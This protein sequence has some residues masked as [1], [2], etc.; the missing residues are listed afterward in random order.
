MTEPETIALREPAQ[1]A[2]I[3][4][5]IVGTAGNDFWTVIL[6][7]F[8][9]IDGLGGKDTLDF[10]TA[11]RSDFALTH[12]SEGAI[13]IDTVSGAS[14]AFHTTA[15]NVEIL[16]FNNGKDK[17]DVATFFG[18]ITPPTLVSIDP[19]DGAT[20][21]ASGKNIKLTFS[22]AVH[23]SAG[24]SIVLKSGLGTVVET[25][26][27]GSSNISIAGNVLTIDPTANLLGHTTYSLEVAAGTVEDLSGNRLQADSVATFSTA[28]GVNH[29]PSGA[30]TI[31]GTPLQGQVMS[32]SNTLVDA[33]G[34]GTLNYQWTADG[35]AIVGA[36]SSSYTLSQSVINSTVGVT[37]SYIDG[38]GNVEHVSSAPSAIIGGIY[39]GGNGD[40]FLF[41]GGG[42]DFL[43]GGGGNDILNGLGGSDSYDGGSGVD[44]A[45]FAGARASFTFT[46]ASVDRGGEHV[47]S[48]VNI[49]RLR[50]DDAD[51][52]LDISGNGG[53]A[54]RIY[55]AAFN[56]APDLTGLGF[57]ISVMDHGTTLESVAGGFVASAEWAKLYGANPSNADVVNG[58]YQNVL[59]RAPDPGG[60]KFWIDVLD[61]HLAT[62]PAVLAA[63]SESPEN[64]AALIGAI[65]NGFAYTPFFG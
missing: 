10:G 32:A 53:Q 60:V 14:A 36:T 2:A 42:A 5:N 61:G 27:I 9:V 41:G 38:Q 62:L 6:P 59:H 48:I 12:D 17:L 20:A 4:N 40:D 58:L 44:V 47:G 39:N 64:Q 45:V 24:G 29:A 46:T 26:T 55:Q 3:L 63:F 51:I 8:Y 33:D 15:R 37:I 50:F 35:S 21:V 28:T 65:G 49:E 52:A 31:S 34:L 19:L 57:W 43:N 23:F 16:S 13:H 30:V 11:L 7:G 56:R 22:E 54:Y 18:D 25:Y 1:R